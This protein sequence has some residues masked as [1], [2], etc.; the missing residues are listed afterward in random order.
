MA[1]DLQKL[2]A[3]FFPGNEMSSIEPLG[4]GLI[5]D[6]YLVS[7]SGSPLPFVLQKINKQVFS[8]PE[9]VMQ[10]FLIISDH[11]TRRS[12]SNEYRSLTI[13]N[14]RKGRPYVTDQDGNYWRAMEY[15]ENSSTLKT[16]RNSQL[17][18]KSAKAY[19]NFIKRLGSLDPMLIQD[20]IVN[21]HQ[22]QDRIEKFESALS[23]NYK[24]RISHCKEQIAKLKDRQ[25]YISDVEKLHLPARVIHSDAK[26][27]NIL[28]DAD[29]KE[30][31]MV[32][33][34][35]IA[36]RGPAMYDYGDMVRSFTNSLREDDPAINK[37][38][39][40]KKVLKSLTDGFITETKEMLTTEEKRN[41]YMGP[42]LVVYIQALRYLTD[43]LN[44]DIYYKT[45]Y[46]A[47]NLTRT[48]NQ[49][50]FLELPEKEISLIKNNITT[51]L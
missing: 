33:D 8:D 49:L 26:I 31:L 2:V 19:G 10:N 20:T 47:H 7:G 40:R 32:I 27:D 9:V 22:Y 48:N 38:R 35:D 42:F 24:N 41:L 6:T 15:L 39:I 13:I 44:G 43:Y 17:A 46:P 34:L 1:N 3:K 12:P 14:S 4:K 36:M 11:L 25:H 30:A 18:Y 23:I 37:I 21:F 50:Q 45:S 28:F 29:E 51:Y 5:N 16:V